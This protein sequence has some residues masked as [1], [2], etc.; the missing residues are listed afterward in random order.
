MKIVI[1]LSLFSFCASAPSNSVPVAKV[2]LHCKLEITSKVECFLP[3]NT[4]LTDVIEITSSIA[5]TTSGLSD[6]EVSTIN[7]RNFY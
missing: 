7:S 1:F 5:F 2:K 4:Q 6:D 3:Q